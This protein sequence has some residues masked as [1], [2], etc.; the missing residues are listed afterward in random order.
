MG[1]LARLHIRLEY[2]IFRLLAA[3]GGALPLDFVSAASGFL[4]RVIAPRLKRQKRA[5]EGLAQAFPEMSLAER[6]RVALAMWDNLGRSFAEFFYLQQIMA[7]GRIAFEPLDRFEAIFAGGPFVICTLH[8]G[9]WEIAA[10]VGGRFGAPLAGVYQALTNPLV[11]RWTYE[12]RRPLYGGGLFDKSFSTSRTLLKLARSGGYPAIVADLREGLGIDVP[13][14]G[15]MASSNPFPALLARVAGIPLYAVRVKRVGGVHFV[16]RIEPVAV[17][18]SQNRD[19]D[20]LAATAALQARFEEFIREAPEQWMWAHRRWA[21]RH[22]LHRRGA[23][24]DDV[25][26]DDDQG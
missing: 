7:E 1:L 21:H 14:F 17:P 24:R 11:D 22:R 20:V 25:E 13:F 15:H 9:N 16:M 19:A 4:W 2:A 12:Q 10:H 23:R 6:E 5:L 26:A 3:I 8:M 18:V